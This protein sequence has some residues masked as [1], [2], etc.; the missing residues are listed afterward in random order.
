MQGFVQ[1]GVGLKP[2]NLSNIQ[3]V[4]YYKS[5]AQPFVNAQGQRAQ[6]TSGSIAIEY[7]GNN[8][9]V[10][11]SGGNILIVT[12]WFEDDQ[13]VVKRFW[14]WV[15][16]VNGG[17]INKTLNSFLHNRSIYGVEQFAITNFA[18]TNSFGIKVD[19]S[20][21]IAD[22]CQLAFKYDNALNDFTYATFVTNVYG[23]FPEYG[24]N[25]FFDRNRGY[26]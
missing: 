9:G 26:A 20:M 18:N 1:T 24:A 6:G 11:S 16:A 15:N 7:I 21:P 4:N 13:W 8:V 14:D 5:A 19:E 22:L 10:T 12:D 3:A 17:G 23:T 25:V 2:V